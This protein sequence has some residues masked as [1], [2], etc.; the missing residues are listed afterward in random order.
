MRPSMQA[1]DLHGQCRAAGDDAA[2]LDELASAAR[3]SAQH[4]DAAVLVEAL[5]LEGH[6]HG[7]VAW[8]TSVGFD[9]KAPAAVGRREGAQQAVA[10]SSDGRS[11]SR[12]SPRGRVARAGR[13]RC[14]R[15]PMQTAAACGERAGADQQPSA[16]VSDACR[17]GDAATAGGELCAPRLWMLSARRRRAV[18]VTASRIRS[19]AC[20][21]LLARA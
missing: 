12:A 20:S 11:R 15:R 14:R 17:E 3:G 10:R 8:S 7:E 19:L 4:V 9:G 16:E 18:F 13:W 2:V 1:R 5:V 21:S 6:Q